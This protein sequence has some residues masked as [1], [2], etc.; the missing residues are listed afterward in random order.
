MRNVLREG[1]KFRISCVQPRGKGTTATVAPR[2]VLWLPLEKQWQIGVC[3]LLLRL[4]LGAKQLLLWGHLIALL[5]SSSI[6]LRQGCQAL[7]LVVSSGYLF[8]YHLPFGLEGESTSNV[9]LCVKF[10]HWTSSAKN[11]YTNISAEWGVNSTSP[12]RGSSLLL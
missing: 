2:S 5:S 9:S 8:G 10:V 7:P 11:H 3:P 4:P 1:C 12:C 6:N